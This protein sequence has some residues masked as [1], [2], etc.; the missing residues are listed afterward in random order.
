MGKPNKN[1]WMI[2]GENPFPP[3]FGFNI[4]KAPT[5]VD[6]NPKEYPIYK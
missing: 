6:Y 5:K 2:W 1:P 4:Q 3:I